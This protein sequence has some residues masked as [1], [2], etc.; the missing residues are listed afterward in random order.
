VRIGRP[1]LA[2]GM[3]DDINVPDFATAVGLLKF[4]ADQVKY[5][6]DSRDY[7]GSSGQGLMRRA[8][9]W[10]KNMFYD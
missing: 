1:N 2:K 6:N 9:G 7:P 8:L 3:T 5:E 4:A 10:L